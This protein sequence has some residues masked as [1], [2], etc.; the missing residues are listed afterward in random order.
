MDDIKAKIHALM[1]K[2]VENGCTEEEALAASKKVQEM[3]NKYQLSLSDIRI[4]Q[5]SNCR[6][7]NY[8]VN[9]SKPGPL[10]FC[11]SGVAYFTDTKAWK[12]PYGGTDGRLAYK[13]FGLD[14]DVLI[15]EYITKVLDWAIIYSGEDFKSSPIYNAAPKRAKALEDFKTAMACRLAKRLREMKDQQTE[16]QSRGRG[17]IVLKG[18]IVDEEFAKLNMSLKKAKPSKGKAINAAAWNAG[19]AA[20]DQVQLN[21]G[22]NA[23]ARATGELT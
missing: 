12:E 9:V 6:K 10:D 5:E 22:V 21:P 19:V 8:D 1:A 2:T 16:S 17:L 20:G 13:F 23:Q 11:I 3:L 4:R 14:H 18:S 15:A 7:G